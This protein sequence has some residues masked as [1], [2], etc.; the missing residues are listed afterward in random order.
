[1]N[2]IINEHNCLSV[3]KKGSKIQCPHKRKDGTDL[4]GIHK[5]SK[6]IVYVTNLEEYSQ[7]IEKPYYDK[8]FL[9]TKYTCENPINPFNYNLRKK[10]GEISL[11]QM[12]SL[13]VGKLRNTLKE[14]DLL[15]IINKNQSKQNILRLLINFLHWEKYMIDNADKIIL[16]QSWVRRYNVFKRSKTVNNE[17]CV[18][19]ISK[20]EIPLRFYHTLYDKVSDKYYAFDLRSLNN[21][22]GDCIL[23]KQPQNPFTLNPLSDEEIEKAID[24][25]NF[26]HNKGF[27]IYFEK[28]EVSE[29]KE[30]EFMAIR[31][32]Q[33]FNLLG[34]YTD[35]EW[36]MNLNVYGLRNLYN[37]TEDMINYRI[38]LPHQERLKYFKEGIS[39]PEHSSKINLIN[40]LKKLRK[41]ILCEYDEI[42]KYNSNDGDKKTAIMWLLIALTEASEDARIALPHLNINE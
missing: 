38:N 3:K 2:Y 15:S 41:M 6:T 21:I 39:F 27:N 31:I 20:Y 34:N 24:R 12:K 40:S 35:H 11:S 4:C 8:E 1:M 17:E 18:E 16:I 23:T 28:C 7:V 32:F 42:L 25:I 10:D 30:I 37:K 29:E 13:K 5:R 36:L 14:Y 33:E 9:I 26:L 19:M 22:I